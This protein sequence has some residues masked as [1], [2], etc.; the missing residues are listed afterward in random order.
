MVH[1]HRILSLLLIIGIGLLPSLAVRGDQTENILTRSDI[2]GWSNVCVDCPHN[3][4]LTDRS[5]QLNEQGY[6][7]LA[8]GKDHLY[9][10]WFDGAAWNTAIVDGDPK[11][12]SHASLILD[13]SGYAHISYL[14]TKYDQVRYAYQDASGW[15]TEMIYQHDEDLYTTAIVMDGS[16]N[17]WIAFRAYDGFAYQTSDVVV[18]HIDG[19]NWITETI[20]LQIQDPMYILA[21]AV[22][23]DGYPRVAYFVNDNRDL[24]YNWYDGTSWQFEVVDAWTL[25]NAYIS[26]VLDNG[27]QP[28]ISFSGE[29]DE[30]E[31]YAYRDV[32]GWHVEVIDSG[33]VLGGFTS[34]VLDDSG[35]SVVSYYHSTD[36][37]RIAVREGGVWQTSS[38]LTG[39]LGLGTSVAVD[40]NT[41]H[42]VYYDAENFLLK[43]A[44]NDGSGW[45]TEAVDTLRM[46]DSVSMAIDQNGSA[47]LAYYLY[48]SRDLNYA[49]AVGG[50]WEIETVDSPGVVGLFPSLAVDGDGNPGI[51]Y[52]DNTNGDL[53]YAY[54]DGSGWQIQIVDSVGRV[55]LRPSMAFDSLGYAHIA[56]LEDAADYQLKY[57]HQDGSGW[58]IEGLGFIGTSDH[59]ISLALDEDDHPHLAYYE[60]V[61]PYGMRHT[62]HDGVSWQ[63]ETVTTSVAGDENDLV[64]N[65]SGEACMVLLG[66]SGLTYYQRVGGIWQSELVDSQVPIFT[67]SLALGADDLAHIAYLYSSDY[68]SRVLKYAQQTIT[69]WQLEILYDTANVEYP[70]IDTTPGGLPRVAFTD[71]ENYDIRFMSWYSELSTVYIPLVFKTP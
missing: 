48:N 5:L 19:S 2:E 16:G 63:V 58:Q 12:G 49:S 45:Q 6:P 60:E 9:F 65:S 46:A 55:G 59:P 35:R 42:I 1:V 26:M 24:K 31:M 33:N 61:T 50:G 36:D 69:G 37:L 29:Y 30:V 3:F 54:H 27:D 20:D 13:A 41:K 14:N 22:G 15:H 10:T 8:Y 32:G 47:R 70:S 28:H 25:D 71:T 66:N 18:A 11:S 52:F 57:A 23:S 67:A 39:M 7:R 62:S 4:D 68:L 34:L 38:I 17:P 53:K 21:M 64:I 44:F 40:S 51:S 56:Y 43:H